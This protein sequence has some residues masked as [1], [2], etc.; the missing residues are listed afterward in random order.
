M[1]ERKKE[2]L[3]DDESLEIL[4]CFVSPLSLFYFSTI[5]KDIKLQIKLKYK[6]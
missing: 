4:I 1:E 2:G 5:N 3:K 6:Q